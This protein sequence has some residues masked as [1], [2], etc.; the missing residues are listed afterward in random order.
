MKMKKLVSVSLATAM[1]LSLAPAAAGLQVDRQA[2]HPTR[3]LP[4]RQREAVQR[5]GAP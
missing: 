2:A 3:P 4:D 1:A 5:E